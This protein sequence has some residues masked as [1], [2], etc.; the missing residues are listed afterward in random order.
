[1]PIEAHDRGAF[2]HS[3]ELVKPRRPLLFRL[4][5]K[6]GGEKGRW[7]RLVRTAGTTQ[8]VP[9]FQLLRTHKLTLRALYC[10]PPVTVH[11]V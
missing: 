11:Q 1:M 8:V 4:A 2:L 5:G 6:E 9:D 3:R 10:A 7:L